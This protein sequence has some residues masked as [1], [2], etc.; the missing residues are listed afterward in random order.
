MSNH[1]EPQDYVYK[2]GIYLEGETARARRLSGEEVRPYTTPEAL[3]R[4]VLGLSA[5][6]AAQVIE[7]TD[8]EWERLAD[9]GATP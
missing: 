7:E 5:D 4:R 3:A 2:D 1:S 9:E 6:K 8:E